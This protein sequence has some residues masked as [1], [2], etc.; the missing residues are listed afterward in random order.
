[1][2]QLY[3]S[4]TGRPSIKLFCDIDYDPFLLMQDQKKVYGECSMIG[5]DWT[6]SDMTIHV[7]RIH[8]VAIRVYR[9]D[10][11]ALERRQG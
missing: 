9:D 7:V 1:M 8:T 6:I 11:Y 5:L 2:N 4:S 3:P 10:P